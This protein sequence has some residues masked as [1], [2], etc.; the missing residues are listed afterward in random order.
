MAKNGGL[1]C[2]GGRKTASL[3][4][5]LNVLEKLAKHLDD[6]IHRS[7]GSLVPPRLL[8]TLCILKTCCF[9]GG[10]IVHTS[11]SY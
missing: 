2:N 10:Y 8:C 6:S 4:R 7:R 11:I 3:D 1:A 5:P 9:M